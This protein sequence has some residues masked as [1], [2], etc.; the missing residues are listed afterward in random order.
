[1]EEIIQILNELKS[2]VDFASEKQIVTG[3]I[4]ESIDITTLITKLEDTF[5]IEI[6]MEYMENKNFDSAEAIW[7]MVQELQ[8]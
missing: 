2:G 5:G 7:N 6:T 4:L 3:K 1:M 8:D